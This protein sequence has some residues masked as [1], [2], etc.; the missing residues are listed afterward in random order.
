LGTVINDN[1]VGGRTQGNNREAKPEKG[2]DRICWEKEKD[3]VI[4][5]EFT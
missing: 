5:S 2:H 3:G 4:K 1:R